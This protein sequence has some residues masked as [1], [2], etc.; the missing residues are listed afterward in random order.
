MSQI[1]DLLVEHCSWGN[2]SN[3]AALLKFYL[4]SPVQLQQVYSI[5]LTN[6]DLA[7]IKEL[8]GE[9]D[10]YGMATSEFFRVS[11]SLALMAARQWQ[12]SLLQY[13]TL[14]EATSSSNICTDGQA[15][16]KEY[17]LYK[18]YDHFKTHQWL[19]KYGDEP[20]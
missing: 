17:A 4:F 19:R 14:I 12:V 11:S 13:T 16:A 5:A 7:T 6:G 8:I 20:K 1:F 18:M 2:S 9:L 3:V 15:F 10:F